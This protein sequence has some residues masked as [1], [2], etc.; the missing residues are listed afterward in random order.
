VVSSR[1]VEGV[2]VSERPPHVLG[3]R[4]GRRLRDDRA[5]RRGAFRR[6]GRNLVDGCDAFI[7]S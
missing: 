1:A 7:W 2:G 6:D 5:G 3:Q 4:D